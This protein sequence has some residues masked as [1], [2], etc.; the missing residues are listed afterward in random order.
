V[1]PTFE[2]PSF[3]HSQLFLALQL[4]KTPF[5]WRDTF[6]GIRYCAAVCAAVTHLQLLDRLVAGGLLVAVVACV[7]AIMCLLCNVNEKKK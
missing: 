5:S 7:N 6:F 3:I 1:S 2:Q 4:K